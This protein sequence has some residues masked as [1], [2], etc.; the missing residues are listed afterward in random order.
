ERV[1]LFEEEGDHVVRVGGGA[2]ADF[3]IAEAS[4][5]C[6]YITR[7]ASQL[8]LVPSYARDMRLNANKILD[9]ITLPSSGVIEFSTH[10]LDL[11]VQRFAPDDELMRKDTTSSVELEDETTV[12]AFN[13]A[14]VTSAVVSPI[15]DDGGEA[16]TAALH[17]A[18]GDG[19]TREDP[20]DVETQSAPLHFP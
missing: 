2:S 12:L 1:F 14:L 18:P 16:L 17:L 4:P 7:Q 10:R 20:K 5:L 11:T 8:I 19:V 6:F 9:V 3:R 15:F 13:D